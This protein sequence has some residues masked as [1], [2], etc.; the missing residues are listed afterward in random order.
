MDFQDITLGNTLMSTCGTVFF[1]WGWNDMIGTEFCWHLVSWALLQRNPRGKDKPLQLLL[2]TWLLQGM[3]SSQHIATDR[4]FYHSGHC[5]Y[6]F[7]KADS[8][9][10]NRINNIWMNTQSCRGTQ[11]AFSK[12]LPAFWIFCWCP[13]F[14]G[15]KFPAVDVV[16]QALTCGDS[17]TIRGQRTMPMSKC[18]LPTQKKCPNHI[19]LNAVSLLQ[20]KN[21]NSASLQHFKPLRGPENT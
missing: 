16:M 15:V 11:K 2:Q 21:M 19:Y 4:L 1:Q 18:I 10:T 14:P 6:Q 9:L 17:N 12:P 3:P 8:S 5:L 7:W 13:W 20:K